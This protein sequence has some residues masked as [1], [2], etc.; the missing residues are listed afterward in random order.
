M[1][2]NENFEILI[3]KQKNMIDVMRYIYK[4]QNK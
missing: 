2:I 3:I 1:I 4:K